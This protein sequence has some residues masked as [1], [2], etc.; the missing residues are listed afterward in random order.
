MQKTLISKILPLFPQKLIGPSMINSLAYLT[1]VKDDEEEAI[2]ILNSNSFLAL[3]N[4][5]NESSPFV[6]QKPFKTVKNN[7]EDEESIHISQF[8]VIWS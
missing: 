4:N 2:H 8:Y 3:W 5:L 6:S 7:D 1:P